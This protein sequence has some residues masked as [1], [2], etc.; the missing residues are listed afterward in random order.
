MAMAA[1]LA[2]R[3]ASAGAF[4]RMLEE[5]LPEAPGSDWS[6]LQ[7]WSWESSGAEGRPEAETEARTE[8]RGEVERPAVGVRGSRGLGPVLATVA[9]FLVGGA[10]VGV[11]GLLPDDTGDAREQERARPSGERV[12]TSTPT[13][14]REA[15]QYRPG[16]VRITDARISIEVA[17]DD[18]SGRT[19]THY[20][21]GG[22]EGTEKVVVVPQGTDLGLHLI[23]ARRTGGAARALYEPVLQSLTE[24]SSPGLLFSGDRM[25]GRLVNG[26]ASRRLPEGRAL[27]AR[28]GVPPNRS[29]PPGPLR[30]APNAGTR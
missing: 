26:T 21:V 27:L 4:V 2:E 9:A 1:E 19:A 3:H 28:R 20:V 17:W 25:E 30:S 5:I 11:M 22:P 29:R 15:G 7:G 24:M 23:V 10:V 13:A 16:K 18:H 12:P 6:G 14:V 8:P